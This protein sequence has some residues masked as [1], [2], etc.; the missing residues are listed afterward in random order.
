MKKLIAISLITAVMLLVGS[1]SAP[2][3]AQSPASDVKPTFI[4]LTPGLYVHGWPAFT[5]T[6]PKEWAVLPPPTGASFLAGVSRP[7]LPPSPGLTISV[8]TIP[9]PL[10]DCWAKGLMP[11]YLQISTDIKVLSDKPS[12]MKDGTPTREVE[13]EL[14]LK[15]GLKLNNFILMTKKDLA[16]INITLRDEKGKIGE[17][18]KNYAY[19]LT[20][21]QGR[22]EPVKVPP[23]VRA[24]LDKHS[25]DMVSHDVD[26]IMANFSDQFLHRGQNK[27]FF[28]KYFR[29]FLTQRDTILSE[30]TVT[31]FEP[32]GDKAY[33]DGFFL[34][35]AKGDANAL[36]GPMAYQQIIKEN[37]QWKWYGNQK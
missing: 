5:V 4:T 29:Q 10:E 26:R 13:F 11:M 7:S 15:N 14:V 28:E 3:Q 12:Q 19:S 23:D 17:D 27:A 21:Q 31:V 18:L 34:T 32:H 22:E 25:S 6:Y 1:F 24:F 30:A 36:K 35:K 2:T 16:W 9:L 8:T 20:F 37:G 33:M